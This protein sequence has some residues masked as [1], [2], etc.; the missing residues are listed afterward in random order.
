MELAPNGKP[1]VPDTWSD[2]DGN[3]MMIVGAVRRAMKQAGWTPEEVSAFS[4]EA[5]SGNY[6]HVLQACMAYTD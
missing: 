2:G 4:T 5:L 6:D 3:A 1:K